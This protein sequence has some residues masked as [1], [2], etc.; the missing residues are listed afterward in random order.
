MSDVNA[1]I[2][3]ILNYSG[4]TK[5]GSESDIASPKSMEEK[6]EATASKAS[7]RPKNTKP[8]SDTSAFPEPCG[9]AT[10]RTTVDGIAFDFNHGARV[11]LPEGRWHVTF[12]DLDRTVC[13]YSSDAGNCMV[14]GSKKYFIRTRIEVRS[15]ETGE[16]VFTHD[17]NCEDRE[18]AILLPGETLGDAIGW[19]SYAVQ[20]QKK[21]RCRLTV[22]MNPEACK[23]F[24]GQ[25]PGIK[26]CS[27]AEYEEIKHRTYATYHIGLYFHDENHDWQPSDFRLVGLHRTA[28][29]ILGVDPEEKPPRIA[30]WPEPRRPIE[31]P[32][33]VIAT[34]ASSQCKIW[35]NP[36]GWSRVISHLK[37]LG[38]EV[39]CIDK[40][41]VSGHRNH[42]NHI[43]HGTR[44]ETGDRPLAERAY[45]LR[46]AAFF[47]GL[48]SGLSWLAW[49]AGTPVVMISGFTHPINEFNTPYR[50]FNPH[51]CN[52]C[53][54]DVR[55]PF[56]HGNL[57]FCPRHENTPRHFECT[58]LIMAEHV[59]AYCDDLHHQLSS[60]RTSESG[61]AAPLSLD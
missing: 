19:F 5:T 24:V 59:I 15:L 20:F 54:H 11:S 52:S 56:E 12:T 34:Q 16:T 39:V 49:A 4:T 36:H 48:S 26:C 41:S 32:Y 9:V 21:H 42:W 60:K 46:H 35:N 6:R 7:P 17:F 31:N 47:V 3:S 55:T 28:A 61:A 37:S 8:P 10:Q 51:V 13:L 30:S 18:V 29:H 58:R 33:V 1:I 44:D 27:F 22:A 14:I 25:Y 2:D 50:V 23:L 43:P 57:L 40:A 53:W 38:Y 45:W